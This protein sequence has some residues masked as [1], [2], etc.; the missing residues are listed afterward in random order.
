MNHLPS[1]Q[2]GAIAVAALAHNVLGKFA[3]IILAVAGT[4]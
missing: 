1:R 4:S 2:Q 3:D